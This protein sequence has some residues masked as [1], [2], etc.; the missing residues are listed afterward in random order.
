TVSTLGVGTFTGGATSLPVTASHSAT[1]ATPDALVPEP[2]VAPPPATIRRPS[3]VN[4]S[5]LAQS[6]PR[7]VRI[8]VGWGPTD[9]SCVSPRIGNP[10]FGPTHSPPETARVVPSGPN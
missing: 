5:Q 10:S 4:V 7:S 3:G 6:N 9:Q 8:S 2:G 1:R